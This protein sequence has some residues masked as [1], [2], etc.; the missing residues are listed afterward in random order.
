MARVVFDVS[1]DGQG[2]RRRD[3]RAPR[4]G[5]TAAAAASKSSKN[6]RFP[7]TP[8]AEE[9]AAV[10]ERAAGETAS[11]S[12]SSSSVVDG[13]L[14]SWGVSSERVSTRAAALWPNAFSADAVSDAREGARIILTHKNENLYNAYACE[15]A[16]MTSP[17]ARAM[18]VGM[19][20]V[21]AGGGRGGETR[22]RARAR[23]RPR[24]RR[25]HGGGTVGRD[26]KASR[27]RERGGVVRARVC[28]ETPE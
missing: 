28:G 12:S 11:T 24:R 14:A 3:A 9:R 18:C 27:S 6:G 5:D 1:V 17:P 22:A 4:R 2:A 25:R 19:F 7:A 16:V 20:W 21:A 13:A 8:P 10:R 26:F 23:D 15:M